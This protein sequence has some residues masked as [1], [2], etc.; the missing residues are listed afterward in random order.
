MWD[1]TEDEDDVAK[2][3]RNTELVRGDGRI[4]ELRGNIET[5]L[6]SLVSIWNGDSEVADVS[7]LSCI[8]KVY[9]GLM[10]SQYHL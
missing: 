7:F 4:L 3:Q 8:V 2:R 10:K 9:R 6:S 5:A 1:L